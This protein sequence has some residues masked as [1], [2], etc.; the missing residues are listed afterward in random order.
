MGLPAAESPRHE[1][2]STRTAVTMGLLAAVGFTVV[3]V[4]FEPPQSTAI[5]AALLAMIYGVYLGFAL[6]DG[7]SSVL[8]AETLFIAVGLAL[9]VCGLRYGPTWIAVGLLLHGLWDILHR[10][11]RPLVGADTVPRWYVPFCAIA[12]IFGAAAIFAAA[13]L[14][15]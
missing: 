15:G 2:V 14:G 1:L 11:P 8:I 10:Q 6:L 7:R 4:V 9:T 5:L 13:A 12:D 3:V